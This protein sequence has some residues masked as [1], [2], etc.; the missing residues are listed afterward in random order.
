LQRQLLARGIETLVHYPV[1]IPA[2]PA[3]RAVNPAACPVAARACD[4]VLSLPLH[5]RLRDDEVDDVAT[6]IK[7]IPC[8][9]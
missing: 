1:P 8:V 9:L 3:M 2:Q 5:Q 7:E 6:A 4:E